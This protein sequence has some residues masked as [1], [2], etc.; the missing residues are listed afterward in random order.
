[1]IKPLNGGKWYCCDYCSYY[2]NLIIKALC[3]NARCF[4]Y[5][6]FDPVVLSLNCAAIRP[7]F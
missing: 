1:M 4:F 7:S 3:G 2:L 6:Y 5:T